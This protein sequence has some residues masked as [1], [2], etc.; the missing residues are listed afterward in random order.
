MDDFFEEEF[1]DELEA[2]DD[3][4]DDPG[5]PYAPKSKKTLQFTT[6]KPKGKHPSGCL[7]S[8]TP[9]TPLESP[10]SA[11]NGHVKEKRQRDDSFTG[12]SDSEEDTC[13]TLPKIGHRAKRRRTEPTEPRSPTPPPEQDP[14]I[15]KRPQETAWTGSHPHRNIADI[16]IDDFGADAI[17]DYEIERPRV[18]S[19]IP[20]GD[21]NYISVT[22]MEGQRAYMKL[23][24]TLELEKEFD[25]VG[26]DLKATQ[27]LTI[28][29]SVLRYQAEEE[30]RRKVIEE[31]ERISQQINRDII[32]DFS[33]L[34]EAENKENEEP[35]RTEPQRNLWVEK[36]APQRYTELLSEETLNRTLLHWLKLWDFVVFGRDLPVK[37][38]K[39]DK[40]KQDFKKWKQPEVLDELDKFNRPQQKVTLLCGPPGLGKTTLAHIVARHAGYNVVE[41]NASDDRSADVFRN[42]LEAATQMKA[43]LGADPRPNCLVIDEID[44]APQAAINI[45]LNLIK[46]T[47][48]ST[49]KKKNEGGILY[50]PIICICND[51]YVP[52]LRQLRPLAMILH[53]PPTEPTRLASRLYEIVREE[54]IKAEMNALLALCEKSENDIRSCLNTLQFVRQKKQDFNLR[55]V[56]NLTVGQKDSH[57][58]MFSLWYQIFSMPRAKKNKFVNIHDLKNGQQAQKMGTVTS[59]A[60][61]F[62]TVL[63]AAQAAGEYEKVTQGVFENYLE[64]KCKDPR[65][66]ALNSAND[67]L[68]F[69]DCINKYT[70]HKQ[71]YSLMKYVPFTFVNF[72]LL[73]ASYQP[74]KIQ[75]P[76]SNFEHMTR[77]AKSINLVTCM[78]ADMSPAVKKFINTKNAVLDML[79]P[80]LQIMQP[81][82]RPVN[83][84]LYSKREKEELSNLVRIMIAYNMTYQQE[85][86]LEGQYSYVLDP[87]VEEIVKFPGMK[88]QR[89]LTYAAKQLIAREIE[90]E[91][92]R[93]TEVKLAV[94]NNGSAPDLD[95]IKDN[96]PAVPNHKRKLEAKPILEDKPVKN[97]FGNFTKTKRT[98]STV[99][100]EKTKSPEGG[101][102]KKDVLATDVWFH[103]KEGFSNAVRRTVRVQDFL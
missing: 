96:I 48:Q 13:D 51:Q 83:T 34:D 33:V 85:K 71:D 20:G 58:S 60:N 103:F 64:A 1:A 15:Q 32:D 78:F 61:R 86:S 5:D 30:R 53:F 19:R 98:S 37:K 75:Y 17:D 50:R 92:M 10:L 87:N 62:H 56:Q 22:N 68:V 14:I 25:S 44:G 26:K 94:R 29:V 100:S 91:K 80:M 73:Y 43:V 11:R 31:A 59:P 54:R 27:L 81:T 39:K 76:S 57:K 47:D 97:F 93:M 49:T 4:D 24:D 12:L 72:H 99:S 63:L 7:V 18:L 2:L 77:L 9:L 42:K 46:R 84:Q 38:D 69:V 101:K 65:L 55:V 45:L 82:L 89:Q 40:K 3:C 90:L 8:P 23:K 41:M 95:P 28:P 74:P 88:Q 66:D 52:A 16:D 70:V 79:H 6:P 36:Y 21:C 35:E 102:D 67:W